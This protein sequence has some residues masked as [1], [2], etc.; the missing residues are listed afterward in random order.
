[1]YLLKLWP[2][3]SYAVFYYVSK[4]EVSFTFAFLVSILIGYLPSY[5][6]TLNI[7]KFD[8]EPWPYFQK[9]QFW[10]NF[11]KYFDGKIELEEKLNNE[12]LYIFCS[13]PHGPLSVNHLLTMTDCCGMLSK[14]YT[15]ARR[16]LA[17]TVLHVIPFLKEVDSLTSYHTVTINL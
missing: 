10:T 6:E 8:G 2:V 1:M 9:L 14:H 15:G 7:A 5:F 12:Q 13:F 16:D 17:A 4:F 11:I 3:F